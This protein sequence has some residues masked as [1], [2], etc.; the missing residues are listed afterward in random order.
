[1]LTNPIL[2]STE[3]VIML[4]SLLVFIG[5][6]SF[7]C[8]ADASAI[9]I[10]GPTY[11]LPQVA[12]MKEAPTHLTSTQIK[13]LAEQA[14]KVRAPNIGFKPLM[15]NPLTL[16]RDFHSRHVTIKHLLSPLFVIGDDADS[17]AWLAQYKPILEKIH[18]IGLIVQANSFGAL[19]RIRTAAGNLALYP[20]NGRGLNQR[21][22]I[23]CYPVLISAHLI[24]H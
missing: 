2:L 14:S 22:G 8:I 18:A 21:F 6:M 3:L 11:P 24:E 17:F 13:K 19:K 15:A 4:M 16:C 7:T 1:M 10:E 23:T 12:S 5:F 9:S 20:A